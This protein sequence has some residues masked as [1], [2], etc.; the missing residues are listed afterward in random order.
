MIVVTTVSELSAVLAARRAGS[1]GFVATMGALHEG[2]LT[3]LREAKRDNDT[4]VLSVFVNPTQFNDPA[5]LAGYPRTAMADQAHARSCCVDIYFAPT[6]TE[7]YPQSF[8]ARVSLSGPI[9]H[10]FEGAHR[11]SGH[12]DG[13]TTVVTKLLMIIRPQRAYFGRKDAQQLM[14]VTALVADLN[15]DVQ[16]VAVATVRDPDGLAMSSRNVRLDSDERQRALGISRAL[17]AG[18]EKFAQGHRAAEV[19]VAATAEVL[20]QHSLTPEYLAVV[21][22]ASF[23]QVAGD[24]QQGAMLILAAQ[25]GGTRLIDNV[26]LGH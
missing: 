7:M 4:V 5:D 16:I 25:V 26:L 21:N 20:A 24:V 22:G 1:I 13:V 19:I 17:N 2:H 12:F 14:V 18:A 6:A 10:T 9:V 3:L 23:R 15:M 8:T 11:G